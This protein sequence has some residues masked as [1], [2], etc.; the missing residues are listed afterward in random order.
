MGAVGG[1]GGGEGLPEACSQ[2]RRD[3]N[4]SGAIIGDGDRKFAPFVVLGL[5]P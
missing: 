3:M 2:A 1:G 4:K 5:A